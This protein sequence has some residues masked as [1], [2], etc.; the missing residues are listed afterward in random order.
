M[1]PEDLEAARADW[2]QV[3]EEEVVVIGWLGT[4]K[5]GVIDGGVEVAQWHT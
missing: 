2:R 4:S 5:R 3:R 1:E